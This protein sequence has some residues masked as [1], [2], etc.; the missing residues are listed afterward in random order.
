MTTPTP[1]YEIASAAGTVVAA[2]ASAW[3]AWI[4][5]RSMQAAQ[6][7]VEEAREA[8]RQEL[9]PRFTLERNFS[10]LHFEWPTHVTDGGW[11]KFLAND[12]LDHSK[13]IGPTFR[14]ENFGQGPALEVRLIFELIDQ[15]GELT[16]PDEFKAVG[17]SAALDIV[18]GGFHLL[19]LLHGPNGGGVSL[20]MY[21]RMRV[22]LP[23]LVAGYPREIAIPD[24]MMARIV[25]RGLQNGWTAP[26]KPLMLIV[27]VEGYTTEG[28]LVADQFRYQIEPFAYGP[29]HPQEAFAH[30][31]DLPMFDADRET[32]TP[33]G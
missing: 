10:A 1:W 16:L 20:P 5:R 18:D 6:A 9:L 31:W 25:A 21:R 15:G 3:A 17:I 4:S 2:I 33:L 22:N 26:L 7:T 30:V 14:L 11:P 28:E 29:G 32:S 23:N 13:L 12:K 19:E 8:R 27:K 24:Q